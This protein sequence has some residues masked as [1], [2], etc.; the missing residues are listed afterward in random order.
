MLAGDRQH[1]EAGRLDTGQELF[2]IG[3]ELAEA[4]FDADL[5]IEAV[6]TNTSAAS[7][8]PSGRRG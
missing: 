4:G 5:Q 2:G 1:R 3:I 6:L 7:M 8:W